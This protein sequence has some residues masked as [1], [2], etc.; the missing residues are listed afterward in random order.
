MGER[1]PAGVELEL[2]LWD[3]ARERRRLHQ[4]FEY[5]VQARSY[6]S[7][8][9]SLPRHTHYRFHERQPPPNPTDEVG[10]QVAEW[11]ASGGWWEWLLGGG[12]GER[13]GSDGNGTDENEDGGWRGLCRRPWQYLDPRRE[14]H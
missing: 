4:V 9:R 11:M 14:W 7:L 1:E 8:E 12:A 10:A 3:E 6:G 13:V 2:P 5:E